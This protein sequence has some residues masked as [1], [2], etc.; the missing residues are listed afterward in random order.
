MIPQ[1]YKI[2]VAFATLAL[3]TASAQ[4]VTIV[5]WGPSPDIITSAKGTIGGEGSSSIDFSTPSNPAIDGTYYP[6]N[7]GHNPVFYFASTATTGNLDVRMLD[8][9]A[10]NDEFRMAMSDTTGD[11][12][13]VDGNIAIMWTKDGDGSNFGFLNGGTANPATLTSITATF[14]SNGSGNNAFVDIYWIIRLGSSFYISQ[15][16]NFNNTSSLPDPSAVNW[17]DYN[18][19]A[20]ST[21]DITAI[22]ASA[23]LANFEDVTGVGF[24]LKFV[25]TSATNIFLL[26]EMTSFT[27]EAD[28]VP[29]PSTYALMVGLAALGG[30][31]W[32]RRK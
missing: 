31:L 32:R 11:P 1:N 2:S 21:G 28:V 16:F 15:D 24:M 26:P 6:D 3:A 27:A 10:N 4:A 20:A 30:M 23:T 29:E 13:E 18:P 25:Q 5:S 22:G 8:G 12:R 9:G 17:F 19:D 7:T 14:N